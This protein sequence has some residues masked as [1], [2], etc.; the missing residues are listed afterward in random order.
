[1]FDEI[2]TVAEGT[3]RRILRM[4]E[5]YFLIACVLIIIGNMVNYEFLTPGEHRALMIDVSLV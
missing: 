1:M 4:R 2:L 3:W 5:V